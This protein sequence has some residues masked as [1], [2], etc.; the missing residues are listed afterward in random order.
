[1]YKPLAFYSRPLHGRG[2]KRREVAPRELMCTLGGSSREKHKI[3]GGEEE[4]E[5]NSNRRKF[6]SQTSDNMDR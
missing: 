1:M 5:K 6:R 4:E 2:Q 3:R